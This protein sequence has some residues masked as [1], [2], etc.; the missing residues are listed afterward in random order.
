MIKK[1]KS[2]IL[3]SIKNK[4][5]NVF[6]LFLMISF[7]ILL[8]TKLSKSYTNTVKFNIHQIGVPEEE[9]VFNNNEKQLNISIK[10]QGFSLLKYYINK[11]L[12]NID[13]D[14]NISKT[15]SFYVWNS[16][17]GYSNIIAQFDK[18]IEI[19]NIN[20]DTLKFRYDINTV[21]K[22]PIILNS[23]I[24]YSQGYDLIN[25]FEIIP[26]SIKLIGPETL[27][28][29]I[30]EVQSDT[31]FLESINSD[32][33]TNLSLLL[34]NESS[35]L[36]YSHKEISV[37]AS[38]GKFTEGNL[39]IPIHVKNIPEGISIKYFPK[40]V[41]VSFYTSL[42]NFNS[43]KIEDFMVE[44]D[45]SEISEKQQVLVPRIVKKPDIVRNVKLH[46]KQIEYII[47]E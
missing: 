46:Q 34:P 8:L 29:Q 31:L 5:I 3:S 32:I 16:T 12:I 40:H 43:I 38:V 35:E 37:L 7:G 47:T 20:P 33:N 27:I 22:V 2:K 26:D 14:K 36:K 25:S 28:E 13:F 24:K 44:C 18:N 21:K 6:L 9:V 23:N 30:N 42:K 41:N 4:R 11:P 17:S 1:I 45:F 10:T 19:I 39:K 15:D